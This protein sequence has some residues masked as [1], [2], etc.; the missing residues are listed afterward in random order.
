MK[1]MPLLEKLSTRK[2][3]R[4]M[5]GQVVPVAIQRP[6]EGE[7][8]ASGE[9]VDI[10]VSGARIRSQVPMRFG[11]KFVL[12]LESESVGLSITISCEVQWIRPG[13]NDDEWIVGSLFDSHI[14]A[15]LLEEYVDIGL[16]ERRESDRSDISL[17]ATI[18]FEVSGDEM[19]VDV[20]NI[21]TGGFCYAAPT[22]GTIGSRVRLTFH[23]IGST[24]VEGRIKWQSTKNGEH[25]VGCQWENRGGKSFAKQIE[26]MATDEDELSRKQ[27]GKYIITTLIIAI[28]AF[29]L[30]M[31]IAT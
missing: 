17:P 2:R 1:T 27:G 26:Q 20:S 16:L 30:G 6:D 15:D 11:E 19:E 25:L 31:W 3:Y 21:G 8:S 10:T 22:G 29:S 18:R 5:L 23:E 28:V 9:L 7:Q 12:H 4:V 14:E 24:V 13:R